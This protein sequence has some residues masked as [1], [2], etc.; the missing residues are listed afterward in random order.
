MSTK[1]F[2]QTVPK[3]LHFIVVLVI[4]LGF[5]TR[6]QGKSQE[7]QS[8]SGRIYVV[9]NESVFE[10]RSLGSLPDVMQ[11]CQDL[12]HGQSDQILRA[13]KAYEAQFNKPLAVAAYPAQDATEKSRWLRDWLSRKIALGD[14][15]P[16][17]PQY[18]AI[19]AITSQSGTY[20][21]TAITLEQGND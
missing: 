18:K 8:E 6:T 21:L 15:V 5:G 16:I 3:T 2:I 17:E 7:I 14:T 20:G 10:G 19:S 9:I 4:C 12:V 11:A 13:G 1:Q